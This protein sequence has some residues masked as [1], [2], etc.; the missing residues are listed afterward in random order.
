LAEPGHPNVEM[1]LSGVTISGMI[2]RSVLKKRLSAKR[3]PSKCPGL[4]S[5]RLA[6][7][8]GPNPGHR[9]KLVP[10][11]MEP[12]RFRSLK[13]R[14]LGGSLMFGRVSGVMEKGKPLKRHVLS[15]G[16]PAG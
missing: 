12:G 1:V 4:R 11:V 9:L 7:V 15:V 6:T 10:T 2:W 13:P 14:L 8:M 3:P 5:V 16:V